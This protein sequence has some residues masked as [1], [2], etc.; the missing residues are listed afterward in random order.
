MIKIDLQEWKIESFS[1]QIEDIKKNLM[2]I[3]ELKKNNQN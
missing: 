2:E 1:K 3:L